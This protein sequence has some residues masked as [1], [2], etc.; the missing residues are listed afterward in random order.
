MKVACRKNWRKKLENFCRLIDKDK[1]FGF[2]I[3]LVMILNRLCA[4]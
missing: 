2:R 4:V 1:T 3:D